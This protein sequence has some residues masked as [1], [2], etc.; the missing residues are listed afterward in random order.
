MKAKCKICGKTI[1]GVAKID[2]FQK[3]VGNKLINI[4]EYYDEDCYKAMLQERATKILSKK[5]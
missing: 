3:K 5:K 2:S 1:V 4:V